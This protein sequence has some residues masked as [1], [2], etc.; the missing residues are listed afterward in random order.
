MATSKGIKQMDNSTL[1]ET[2][3][4]IDDYIAEQQKAIDDG[5]AL[6]RL[7]VNKDFQSLVIDGYIK[8]EADKLFNILTDPNG[9]SP[10]T[11]E[12]ILLKLEVINQFKRHFGTSDYTGTIRLRAETAP[13]NIFRE[14]QERAR[15]TAMYAEQE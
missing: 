13:D 3:K 11:Q 6:D 12:E 2:L 10:Y 8:A 9:A 4:A 7:L 1:E 5:K 14:S 15:I